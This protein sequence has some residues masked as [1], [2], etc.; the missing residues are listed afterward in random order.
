MPIY[1]QLPGE[2]TVTKLADWMEISALLD[3]D[4]CVSRQDLLSP[5]KAEKDT[6]EDQIEQSE[7]DIIV[8]D[9]FT[10][11][12]RR[13]KATGNGYPFFLDG[14]TIKRKHREKN[15]LSYI[16][17]LLIS[18]FGV[19]NIQYCSDWKTSEVT[20]KFEELSAKTIQSL[21]DNK[22]LSAKVKVFGWPRRWD[23]D[24]TN[25]SFV[26]ALKK[27]C[28]ECGEM[29]PKNRPTA[30]TAKDAGLDIIAW[31]RFPDELSGGI[32]FLGQCATGSDWTSKLLDVKKFEVF[33]ED[34]T[35]PVTGTFIPHIPD[36]SNP[37]SIDEWS[38]NVQRGGMLFNRCRI[39][40]LAKDWSDNWANRLC[41]KA[42]KEI[43]LQSVNDFP[44]QN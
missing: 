12:Q 34:Y 5:L 37:R 38:I 42:L 24:V 44:R 14:E 41:R 11:I 19:E 32:F 43:R 6:Q 8:L 3:K 30:S 26:E 4:G 39:A 15:F 1:I 25:P 35:P 40:Y 9:I 16:F 13:T 23:G 21:L 7:A 31:K 36:I 2:Q 20:K 22:K 27:I 29:K 33:I 28:L 10:E 18:F 17:C